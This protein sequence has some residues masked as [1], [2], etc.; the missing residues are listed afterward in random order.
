MN[1]HIGHAAELINEALL[2][3]DGHLAGAGLSPG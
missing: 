3:R 1:S 2:R